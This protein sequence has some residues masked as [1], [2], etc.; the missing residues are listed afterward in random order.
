MFKK[1]IFGKS[2]IKAKLLKGENMYSYKKAKNKFKKAIWLIC[3]MICVSVF[4]ILLYT[5]YLGIDINN[6]KL[7]IDNSDVERMSVS[8]EE[9]KE[10]NTSISEMIEEMQKAVVGISKIKN[11]GSSIFLKDSTSKMEIG[12]GVIVADNG[13]VLTNWHVSGDKY[14]NC[15]ITTEDGKKYNGT[16]V[17]ADS[18][19]DLSIVKISARGLPNIKFGD[20]DNVKIGEQVYAIGNPIG[21]EFQRTVTRRNY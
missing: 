4:S 21:Y 18:N 15:Y 7:T 12:T 3:L 19:I 17:W 9:V 20:S 13:Y 1:T 6:I 14:S 16:V 2:I 10:K 5:I 11:N 8:I